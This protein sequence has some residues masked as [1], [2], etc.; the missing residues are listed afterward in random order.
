VVQG[1]AA[2]GE[3]GVAAAR[4]AAI[5][6]ALALALEQRMGVQ[7]ESER[8]AVNHVLVQSRIEKAAAGRIASYR[9][10]GEGRRG[11]LYWVR[12][13]VELPVDQVER[14]GLD[15]VRLS[16]VV[17]DKSGENEETARRVLREMEDR[18]VGHGLVLQ[19]TDPPTVEVLLFD[20]E[21][22]RSM[23]SR[24]AADLLLVVEISEHKRPAFAGLELAQ[25]ELRGRVYRAM[26]GELIISATALADGE[27]RSTLEESARLA[28]DRAADEL[29]QR[30]LQ[31]LSRRIARLVVR[32]V[33]VSGVPGRVDIDRIEKALVETPEVYSVRLISHGEDSA[34][35]NVELEP[36]AARRLADN[37]QHI[38]DV[39]L[40]V[41]DESGGWL[42]AR[43]PKLE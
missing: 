3:G 34:V 36:E 38:P 39:D 29:A 6:S 11:G 43:Q 26:T 2:I 41:E 27:R 37:L 14:L 28:A 16:A 31:G 40:E 9:L 30:I 42:I 21:K 24:E 10:L 22:I 23:I 8:L 1:F 7:L 12:L 32:R 15:R 13:A 17:V 19:P 35:W 4:E 18:L 25:V 5:A 33:V 20:G